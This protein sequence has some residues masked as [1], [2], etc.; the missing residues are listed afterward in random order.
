MY[1]ESSVPA[2]QGDTAVLTSRDDIFFS[3]GKNTIRNSLGRL[4][5]LKLHVV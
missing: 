2:K 5:H 1:F 3:D 4:G